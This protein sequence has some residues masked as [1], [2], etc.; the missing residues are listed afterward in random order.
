M[1]PAATFDKSFLQNLTVDEAVWFDMYF[2]PVVTPLFFVETLA[3]L[4]KENI[5]AGRTAE[6][7]VR[8]I[9]EKTPELSA[10]MNVHHLTLCYSELRGNPSRYSGRPVLAGARRAIN[11]GKKGIVFDLSPEA[12]A[13]NR[14]RRG[15][16]REVERL[17]AKQWRLA[18]AM[19]PKA[20]AD[21]FLSWERKGLQDCKNVQEVHAFARA[22]IREMRQTPHVRIKFVFEM[23]GLTKDLDYMARLYMTHGAPSLYEYCP[24]TAHVLE[25][26]VFFRLATER[27][28]LDRNRPSDKI[29]IAYLHYLPF[30]QIFVSYDRLHRTIVPLFL[31]EKQMF[32]PGADLKA[33]LALINA[34]HLAL[35][36]ATRNAGIYSFGAMPP[37]DGK[38]LTAD[39][40]DKLMSPNW[41][42]H[43]ETTTTPE[44]RTKLM[45]GMKAM[46]AAAAAGKESPPEFSLDEADSVQIPRNIHKQRGSWFQVAKDYDAKPKD[47]NS[48]ADAERQ[49]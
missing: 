49:N 47:A 21:D 48:Q 25:V 46:R 24:Y 38:F 39:L 43:R 45:E 33:D 28:V 17:F 30:S 1:G 37:T 16:F 20:P 15:E 2:V 44:A 22:I 13:F 10:A 40:W 27:G 32:V 35:P 18:L 11:D 6:D 34:R 31:T 3:D 9:A 5:R 41:R 23:L 7:E 42:K 29:D 14:W 8:I 19:P 36:E 12:D 4:Q 26:E